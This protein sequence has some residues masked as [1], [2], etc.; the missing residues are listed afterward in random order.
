MVLFKIL[1]V[2]FGIEMSGMITGN[3]V[4]RTFETDINAI[5]E[6]G[7]TLLHNIIMNNDLDKFKGI[8]SD[9]RLDVNI[10]DANGYMPLHWAAEIGN[11]FIVSKLIQAGA[12]VD[13]INKYGDT[14][15]H[16]AVVFDHTS[17]A[18]I[19]INAEA[20]VQRAD[21]EGNTALHFASYQGNAVLVKFLLEKGANPLAIN[22]EGK[23]PLD[24][25]EAKS[26]KTV[27][28]ML[29]QKSIHKW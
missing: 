24:F 18:V 4:I 14:P 11:D 29:Q 16:K 20:N 5:D 28:K 15:L 17:T 8:I 22:R 26:H 12:N 9:P 13:P 3:C 19:L 21:N 6:D 1:L 7:R 10:P 23:T 25:A 27:V 2:L